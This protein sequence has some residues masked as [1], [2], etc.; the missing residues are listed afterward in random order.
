M[1]SP[2]AENQIQTGFSLLRKGFEDIDSIFEKTVIG[3]YKQV[4]RN[5]NRE[6]RFLLEI[7]SVRNQAEKYKEYTKK[8]LILA[9]DER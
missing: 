2:L 7:V 6:R 4:P 8:S 3:K 1:K 9:Q 5:N